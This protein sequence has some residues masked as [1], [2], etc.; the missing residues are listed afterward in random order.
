MNNCDSLQ[1]NINT[2][3]LSVLNYGAFIGT[4]IGHYY[5]GSTYKEFEEDNLLVLQEFRLDL[6]INATNIYLRVDVTDIFRGQ[7]TLF[8]K[9]Y[10]T[11]DDYC[12]LIWGLSFAAGYREIPCTSPGMLKELLPEGVII[13]F[14]ENLNNCYC[15]Y[16]P[17]SD[18]NSCKNPNV[19]SNTD[20]FN[21]YR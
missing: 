16:N 13:P 2:K 18:N 7:Y 12:Y 20:K 10:P 8:T 3:I 9:N 1:R 21:F 4:I 11:A 5:I 6:P 17:C 14:N 19:R 15:Q